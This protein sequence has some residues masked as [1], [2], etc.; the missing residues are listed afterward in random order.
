MRY[1]SCLRLEWMMA[2]R[3]LRARRAEGF[4][5]VVSVFSF[6][7]IMLGVATLLVV[8]AVMNGFHTQ[9]LERILGIH[10]HV[11]VQ[12]RG[13]ALVDY[14]SRSQA[15]AQ[16]PEVASATPLI[17]GQALI[18]RGEQHSGA[19]VHGI[20]FQALAARQLIASNLVAGSLDPPASGEPGLVIGVRMARA[21]GVG[22]GDTLRLIAPSVQTTM[23]GHLPRVK[24]YPV[25]AI[26]DVG[27][28]EYDSS[29]VFLPFE[30]GQR[31][32]Q[33][34]GQASAIELMLHDPEALHAVFPALFTSLG[35]RYAITDWKQRNASFFDALTVERNVMFLI[36]TLI[37]LVAAFNIIAGMVM[38]V[39]DKRQEIAILRTIGA[40]RGMLLRI[41]MWAGSLIGVVGTLLGVLLGVSFAANIEAIRQWLEH[42]S[43]VELFSA[44]I[45]FLSTLPV[46]MHGEDV[47]LIAFM[48]LGLSFL[49]TLY[50]AW[51][52]ASLPPLEGL[53]HG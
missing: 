3:Y 32:F 7:G 29:F 4:I 51:K 38:L 11:S 17:Y 47:W 35:P 31:Y 41:F 45:Y 27:M 6:L 9:L 19:V 5:S 43:G 42:L 39:N 12:Y 20:D 30:A 25:Q 13:D 33:M 37:I 36:L 16:L 28:F 53:R 26:F 34:K 44:E 10:A 50:P 24:D 49:A 46:E 18:S 40:T 2:L 14:S 1:L 8:M 48:A 15:L 21:F 23:I 22:P 52:A